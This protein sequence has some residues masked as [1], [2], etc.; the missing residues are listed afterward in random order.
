LE[1]YSKL[2]NEQQLEMRAMHS[3]YLHCRICI[4]KHAIAAASKFRVC[5]RC[6][7][8]R[9]EAEAKSLFAAAK[10]HPGLYSVSIPEAGTTYPSD[11]L[12]QYGFFAA[13]WLYKLTSESAFKT[14]CSISLAC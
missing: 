7:W 13:A 6:L 14:V 4:S 10:A 2:Y 8:C 1:T 12:Q 5:G 11:N 3:V 9:C